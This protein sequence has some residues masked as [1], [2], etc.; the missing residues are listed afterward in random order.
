M[1]C[2]VFPC[3]FRNCFA[4]IS[5]PAIAQSEVA[6]VLGRVIFFRD[7]QARTDRSAS[8]IA[9]IDEPSR[10]E[11]SVLVYCAVFVFPR[12]S[13]KPSTGNGKVLVAIGMFMHVN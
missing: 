3:S 1:T 10:K 12:T 7:Y 8:V 13:F 4:E 5:T 9:D 11:H 6:G 2:Q